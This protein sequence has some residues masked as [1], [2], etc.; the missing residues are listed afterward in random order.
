MTG[1][2]MTSCVGSSWPCNSSRR[3]NLVAISGRRAR[4][5]HPAAPPLGA[6]PVGAPVR[7]HPAGLDPVRP[8]RECRQP[9]RN[10]AMGSLLDLSRPDAALPRPA[11]RRLCELGFAAWETA[12]A[13]S[14]DP[15]HAGSARAWA[16]TEAGKGLLAAIFGNS[17]F[18]A[19]LAVA[20]WRLVLRFVE[21]GPDALFD[22]IAG[23][24]EQRA[25]PGDRLAP[26]I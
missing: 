6:Q 2:S 1:R 20:E 24:V 15:G 18:L 25:D 13:E 16:D 3:P 19:K 9:R 23:G 7:P 11:D 10:R 12:L 17:P 14:A 8:A 5:P 21:N 4:P 22:G 26:L